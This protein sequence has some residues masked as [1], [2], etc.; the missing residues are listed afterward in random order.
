MAVKTNLAVHPASVRSACVVEPLLECQNIGFAALL[1]RTL[2]LLAYCHHVLQSAP[3]VKWRNCHAVCSPD[4][5]F[6]SWGWYFQPVHPQLEFKA[7]KVAC[8]AL[9]SVEVSGR[10]WMGASFRKRGLSEFDDNALITSETRRD[11][12]DIIRRYVKPNEN[13]TRIVDDFYAS[14]LRGASLLGVH[15]RG[16][17]HVS[18][19]RGH[20]LPSL[21]LWIR[22]ARSILA[23]M[24]TPSKIFVAGDNDE[25][26]VAFQ[27][28]FGKNK[29]RFP[30]CL[31]F[32]GSRD[33]FWLAPLQIRNQ[34]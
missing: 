22:E 23:T 32:A 33:T 21:Q 9:V 11:A 18:E 3:T 6:N 13:T 24:P 16:T 14:N 26:L 19:A 27:E 30:S 29:V 2:E 34:Q 25:A 15:V 31:G 4:P 8:V 1:L 7:S 28:A 20:A 12:N 5:Q 10:V 17:D